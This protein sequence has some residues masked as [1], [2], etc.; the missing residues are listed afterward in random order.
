MLAAQAGVVLP[1]QLVEI[2][3]ERLGS[4]RLLLKRDDLIHPD[5]SGNKWRKLEHVL[6]DA[7]A[8]GASTLL[9]F[10]GA[11]SNHIRAVA[12]AGRIFGFRTIGVIRGEER[13]YNASLARAVADGMRLHYLDR[14]TYRRK[15]EP[16]V[17]DQ[18]RARFGDF[19]LIPEGGTTALALR[20]LRRLL[21]EITEPFDLICCPVGTGGTLAGLAA[22]LHP[23]QRALG[24]S[25]LRGARSLDADV[26]ALHQAG[27]GRRLDNWAINH[28]FHFGGFAR[29]PAEL[30]WFIRDFE[31]R[32]GVRLEHVYVAKMMAGLFTLVGRG[33]IEQGATVVALITGPPFPPVATT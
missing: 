9:T 2:S 12:A 6:L 11:Y 22:G 18:L 1:S 8:T 3:D 27:L 17:I 21:D 7:R 5:L 4:V 26:A 14:A 33:E 13:P 24:F 16:A 25:V 10:G 31:E 15:H 29:R 28:D 19:Y 32:H 20:G 23:G 30:D